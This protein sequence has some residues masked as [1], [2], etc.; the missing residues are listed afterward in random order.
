MKTH[1]FIIIGV[2]A[3]GLL[4]TPLWVKIG[5]NLSGYQKEPVIHE[6]DKVHYAD[7]VEIF[8]GFYTG[9][10]GTV[11]KKDSFYSRPGIIQVYVD[12]G[13]Y[14]H[15]IIDVKYRDCRKTSRKEVNNE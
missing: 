15:E 1:N 13:N 11:L 2:L 9:T 7:Y 10:K 12:R 4:L 6:S 8:R 14:D 3:F 5:I